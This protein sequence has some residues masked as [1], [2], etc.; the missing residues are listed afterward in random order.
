MSGLDFSAFALAKILL[1]L[2]AATSSLAS[3]KS[4]LKRETEAAVSL[5]LTR[6]Y[7]TLCNQTSDYIKENVF[8]VYASLYYL[9]FV[10]LREISIIDLHAG[11]CQIYATFVARTRGC[12]LSFY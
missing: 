7:S 6:D 1:V 2:C 8:L 4:K 11:R 9:S 12:G 5:G 3:L 10:D